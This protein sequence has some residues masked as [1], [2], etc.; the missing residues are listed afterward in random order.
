MAPAIVYAIFLV[1][2]G[3]HSANPSFERYLGL[4][5]FGIAP[6]LGVAYEARTQL[7]PGTGSVTGTVSASDEK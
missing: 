6:Y 2:D 3:L 1:V 4:G 5:L 7:G